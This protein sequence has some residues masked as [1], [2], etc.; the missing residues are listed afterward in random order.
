[1]AEARPPLPSFETLLSKIDAA[2]PAEEIPL[3]PADAARLTDREMVR[4]AGGAVREHIRRQPHVQRLFSFMPTMM[5]RLSPFHLRGPMRSRDWPLVRLDTGETVGWGRMAVVGELLVIFD[6]SVLFGL[7]ALMKALRREAFEA[8]LGTLCRLVG[9][10][11]APRSHNTVWQSVRRLAGTRI[12]LTLWTG[13]G[14]RRRAVRTMT[15]SILG[16]ADRE[17]DR[18]RVAF[19]PY[20]LEMYGDSFVTNIDLKFRASLRHDISKAFYRFYQGQLETEHDI[21]LD[22]LARAVNLDP[23]WSAR[24]VTSRVNAGLRELRDR[25]YLAAFEWD[26]GERLRVV[27]EKNVL[28]RAEDRPMLL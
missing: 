11:P 9:V 28:L 2:L 4:E 3:P 27:R 1:M 8:D 16:Y 17:A 21:L 22:E 14:K 20:F 12:D 7:L 19:S 26:G 15:G 5:T 25:G 18:L 6:E 24:Q 23:Q 10:A 13:K